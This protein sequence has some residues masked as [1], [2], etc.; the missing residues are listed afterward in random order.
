MAGKEAEDSY[1]FRAVRKDGSIVW[2]DAYATLI[3][4]NG[5]PSLQAM[6]LD[7]TERKKAEEVVIKSEARYRELANFL[8][9]I[10]F[11]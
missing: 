10:V 2:M 4:Y 3:E 5:Q 6:F 7:I 11:E 9:E 1:E 8:P